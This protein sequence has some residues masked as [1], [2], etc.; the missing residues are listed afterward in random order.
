[1]SLIFPEKGPPIGGERRRKKGRTKVFV[2]SLGEKKGKTADQH[3]S[4]KDKQVRGVVI[5]W[6]YKNRKKIT[7]A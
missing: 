2:P 5:W 3:E 7:N 6:R 4:L 1:V